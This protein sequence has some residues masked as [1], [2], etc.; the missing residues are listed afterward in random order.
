MPDLLSVSSFKTA[1]IFLSV[2][3]V[4]GRP[5]LLRASEL[6][7]PVFRRT[8]SGHLV[9]TGE[10]RP[11]PDRLIGN[12]R[13][14]RYDRP[15]YRGLDRL[16]KAMEGA[17]AAVE[18]TLNVVMIRVAFESNERKDL[19]S[20][21]T[22]GDFDL[23]PY[24]SSIVDPTPHNRR[25]FDTHMQGLANFL[26]FQSCGKLDLTWEILPLEEEG[27]YKLSDI[28][29]Y[30]PGSYTTGW[31]TPLLTDFLSAA[32]TEADQRL[33][34]AGYPRRLSDYDAIILVHA[35]ADMQSDYYGDSPNDLPSF[36]AILGDDD[37]IPIEGGSH[38]VREISVVPETATQ[39]GEYGSMAS[40][41]GHEFGHVLGL[42]DLYDVYYGMPIVGVWDLMDSGP[43]LG[44]YVPDLR[45]EIIY[46]TGMLPSGF[47]AWSRYMLGWAET[48]TVRLFDNDISL[49]AA[50]KCPSKLV[51]LEISNDEY[52]IIENRAV[53]LD[54]IRTIY[55]TDP[56]TG[57]TIGTGN[58]PNCGDGDPEND[59]WELVNGYDLLLPTE[60]DM[61]ET[62]AGPGILVWHVDESFIADRWYINEV[63]SRWPF[64]VSLV[65][66]SGVRD[67]GNP[68]SV[69]RMGWYDD[70]FYE[71]N[72][73][74][75]SDSTLPSSWSNWQV[76]TGS[77]IEGVS[78]RDTLMTFGA[79]TRDLRGVKGF[80]TSS[81][82]AEGGI[83]QLPGGPG[84][85]II[86]LG[87]NGIAAG[88]GGEV[89]SLGCPGITP[90]SYSSRFDAGSGDGAVLAGD[91]D[92]KVHAFRISGGEWDEY[93]GWPFDTGADIVSHPVPVE[94]LDQTF[95]SVIDSE[96]RLRL[97]DFD[98]SAFSTV[99]LPPGSSFIGNI[100]VEF[101][102]TGYSTALY[103]LVSTGADELAR[104]VRWVFDPE[105]QLAGD[106]GWQY[107]IPFSSDDAAGGVALL[108]GDIDPETEGIEV[109][110][111]ALATGRI[112]FC[113]R[114][115]VVSERETGGPITGVPALQD[116]NGDGYIDICFSDGSKIYVTG[117]SGSNISGWPRD[118]NEVFD[119]PAEVHVS[120]PLT[121]YGNDSGAWIAAG[122]S[123]GIFFVFDHRG[124]LVPGYPK[125]MASS[126]DEPA[127]IVA[128][129]GEILFSY[130]DVLV[131]SGE[132]PYFEFRPGGG[133]I[134]WRVAPLAPG[135]EDISWTGLYGGPGRTA[136]AVNTGGFSA[137]V[138]DWTDIE[139]NLVIYPNPSTGERVGFHFT[140][141]VGGEAHIQI[142]TLTGE[143]VAEKRKD[144]SGGEDEF[145]LS[146]TG[147]ASGIYI[148]RLVITSEGK[149]YQVQRKF[150]IVN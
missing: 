132:N 99:S 137:T 80:S 7:A 71:G 52:F 3:A 46:V 87:G 33:F 58:C 69:F 63:N 148:C 129:A 123:E 27:S 6:K 57:I 70:A 86:D 133:K 124:E 119:L 23:S 15:A 118:V 96:G 51:R 21:K 4:S 145:A 105:G 141:P 40:V 134:R 84:S 83:L 35:G 74:V 18:G 73:S 131:N 50:E 127:D 128:G 92:G 34:D 67:L 41:L 64:G 147:K 68:Y 117:H 102:Q 130:S 20:I 26:H 55:A 9:R 136:F 42:P 106:T 44:A 88:T 60:S 38:I 89:F 16:L 149:R 115:G 72:R 139:D 95:V 10:R 101:D 54:D 56:L 14:F 121:A 120:S 62:D 107:Q 150:A 59:E 100:S 79:G 47:G 109:Y 140:A 28:S 78:V 116:I 85:L 114:N 2:L 103:T 146:L 49:P 19:T 31:T 98:G 12:H 17:P 5:A 29:E 82:V 8:Q 65:E 113:D 135:G 125:K 110:L 76:P 48:D 144:L 122:T 94:R 39:D 104:I 43:L 45:G 111:S 66:A 32:V 90:V 11:V 13:Y 61:L 142:M 22:D 112:L 1:L 143:L 93:D 126:F 108:G 53:E 36:F 77:R 25:Y 81:G 91:S 30:G 37:E 75:F 97:L 24:D 138:A